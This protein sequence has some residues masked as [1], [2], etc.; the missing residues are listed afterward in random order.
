MQRKL[1]RRPEL[2]QKLGGISGATFYRRFRHHPDAPK[3][4]D[5]P[6]ASL[7]YF[8]D[9]WD[10]FLERLQRVEGNARDNIGAAPAH[11]RVKDRPAAPIDTDTAA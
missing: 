6:S 1:I 2:L 7:A 11:W 10:E 4:V 5:L 3:P 9:E 8:E